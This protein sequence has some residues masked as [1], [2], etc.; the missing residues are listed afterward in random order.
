M[1]ELDS[2]APGVEAVLNIFV[3][4]QSRAFNIFKNKYLSRGGDNITAQGI[5]GVLDRVRYD[6]I[7]RLK[8]I[9]DILTV[10]R[11]KK[12]SIDASDVLAA[13]S[14]SDISS[15]DSQDDLYDIANYAII[16]VMLFE[17]TWK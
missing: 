5:P 13:M 7:P 6:K 12:G 14:E 4:H 15:L 17:G 11:I 10:I 8:R 16:M 9:S 2:D 3:S 1:I